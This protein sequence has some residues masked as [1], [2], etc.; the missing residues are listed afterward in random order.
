MT[1]F[2]TVIL[3]MLLSGLASAGFARTGASGPAKTASKNQ[4]ASSKPVASTPKYA[5]PRSLVLNQVSP[6][7]YPWKKDITATVFWIGET[8]TANNPTP[9]NK[10]S[11][12]T[13]WQE[14]FGGFDDPNVEKRCLI[15]YRP[16]NFTPRLNPFYIALPYNDCVNSRA[17]KPEAARVI[18][19]FN[20]DFVKPGQSVCKGKWVQIFYKGKYCF[21]QWE[22]CGPFN[23]EDWAY[24]FGSAAPKNNSNK[25]AGIDISPAVRDYLGMKSGE[26][27]HWRFVEFNRIPR[28]PWSKFGDNNPFVK[29]QPSPAE[30]RKAEK[31]RQYAKMRENEEKKGLASLK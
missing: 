9:N 12:D 23:T 10:S 7:T 4:A 24:V 11:W 1:L 30:L 25:G 15:T 17:H 2:R 22:D 13:A 26:K 16:L 19:W 20:R 8:P 18:P 31:L 3:F 28:G 6:G 29:K 21:A 27:V 5:L 14:N